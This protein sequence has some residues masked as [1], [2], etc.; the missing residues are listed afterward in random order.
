MSCRS[1][2][3]LVFDVPSLV[4]ATRKNALFQRPF[5]PG[6]SFTACTHFSL[7][8]VR[9]LACMELLNTEKFL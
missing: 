3:E 7:V 9:H 4:Q 1:S 5:D 8:L 2:V 6:L